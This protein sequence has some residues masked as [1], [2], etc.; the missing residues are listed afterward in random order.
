MSE[1]QPTLMSEPT[2]KNWQCI[3]SD[4]ST[5][6][7][8][9]NCVGALDDKHVVMTAT[10]KSGSLFHILYCADGLGRLFLQIYF[11]DI[12][13][14]G[15]NADGEILTRSA[16][17]QALLDG[18]LDFPGPKELPK[19]PGGGVLPHC[20]VADEAFPLRHDIMRPYPRGN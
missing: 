9:P 16:F 12:C 2:K 20:I 8:F 13:D 10:A 5:R 3:E 15:S 6:W 1:L 7:N 4:F 14:Y 17:V 19:Y 11:V 18:E